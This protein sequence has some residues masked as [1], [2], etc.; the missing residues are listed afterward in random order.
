M[1]PFFGWGSFFFFDEVRLFLTKSLNYCRWQILCLPNTSKSL[2]TFY[3]CNLNCLC[4]I[5]ILIFKCLIILEKMCDIMC[6]IPLLISFPL[7]IKLALENNPCSQVFIS[8]ISITS[9]LMKR[10]V[11]RYWWNN[12]QKRTPL[13][14]LLEL[15]WR[16]QKQFDCGRGFGQLRCKLLFF[17]QSVQHRFNWWG[18]N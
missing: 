16:Y 10:N 6:V 17:Y 2:L 14:Y 15:R 5:A 4:S 1:N 3:S 8:Y 11:L 13:L 7:S 9:L 12:S 18:K